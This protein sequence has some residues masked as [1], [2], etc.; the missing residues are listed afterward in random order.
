MKIS[1]E[2]DKILE[3]SNLGKERP[4]VIAL[5]A[6]YNKFSYIRNKVPMTSIKVQD[7]SEKL[8]ISTYRVRKAKKMLHKM[9]YIRDKSIS[10]P[11]GY[12]EHYII[13]NT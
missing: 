1:K 7:A 11:L 9:G 6:L 12:V 10:N 4:D 13:I 5:L 3:D 2:I 8:S